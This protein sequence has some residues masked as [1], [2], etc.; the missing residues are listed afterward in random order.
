VTGQ[1]VDTAVVVVIAFAGTQSMSLILRMILSSYL[2]KV[3]VEVVATPITYLVVGKLKA[4]E[5]VDVFDRHTDFNPFALQR[6][7]A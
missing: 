1:A 5:G 6:E 2:I 4:A 7:S 3:G